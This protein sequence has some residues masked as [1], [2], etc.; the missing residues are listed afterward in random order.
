M[1]LALFIRCAAALLVAAPFTTNLMAGEAFFPGTSLTTGRNSHSATLLTD[2]R[3]LVAGGRTSSGGSGITSVEIL[4]VSGGSFSA[5]VPLPTPRSGHKSLTLPDSR[6]LLWGGTQ[7]GAEIYDPSSD[8]WTTINPPGDAT[9]LRSVTSF[10]NGTLLFLGSAPGN[11]TWIHDPTQN[12]WTT[13]SSPGVVKQPSSAIRLQNGRVLLVGGYDST[14]NVPQT[15]CELFDPGTGTW[16]TTGSLNFGRNAPEL[17]MLADGSIMAI[18]GSNN[19]ADPPEIFD[20]SQASWTPTGPMFEDRSVFAIAPTGDGSVLVSGGFRTEPGAVPKNL[21]FAS[22]ER[23]D[24]ATRTWKPVDSMGTGRCLHQATRLNDGRILIT[25]GWGY[26]NPAIY[27]NFNHA[28]KT[29]EFLQTSAGHWTTLPPLKQRRHSHS[30]IG[31][32]DGRILAYG[33]I[34]DTPPGSTHAIG[35]TNSADIFNPATSMWQFAASMNAAPY[36]GNAVLL[37]DQ[38]ILAVGNYHSETY[39]AATN[40]WQHLGTG[41]GGRRATLLADGKV[42]VSGFSDGTSRLFN[43]VGTAWANTGGTSGPQYDHLTVRL[44]NGT[45]L[46]IGGLSFSGTNSKRCLIYQNGTWQETGALLEERTRAGALM[47]ADGTVLVC[48]GIGVDG[49]PLKTSELYDPGTGTWSSAGRMSRSID[50]PSLFLV[51]GEGVLAIGSVNHDVSWAAELYDPDTDTWTPASPPEHHRSYAKSAQLGDGR[52]LLTG[53]ILKSTP[54]DLSQIRTASPNPLAFET[55]TGM[56]LA[57]GGVLPFGLVQTGTSSEIPIRVRN[58]GNT[59]LSDLTVEFTGPNADAFSL[60]A[61]PPAGIPAGAFATLQIR[62]LSQTAGWKQA[63][64]T[65]RSESGASLP[66]HLNLNGRTFTPGAPEIR[67][68]G[69][70]GQDLT[71]G[72]TV[73]LGSHSI[74]SP[75]DFVFTI[76]NDGPSELFGLGVTMLPTG[77]S[78]EPLSLQSQPAT[79]ELAAGESVT[80][81]VRLEYPMFGQHARILR[82]ISN[83]PDESIFDI[84][85]EASTYRPSP[86]LQIEQPAGIPL[87]ESVSTV[88]FGNTEVGTTTEK[89]FRLV[90]IGTSELRID[91]TYILGDNPTDFTFIGSPSTAEIAPGDHLDFQLMFTP[92]SE[93]QREAYLAVDSNDPEESWFKVFLHGSGFIPFPEISVEQDSGGEIGSGAAPCSF[94][95]ITAG[96][97]ARMEFIVRNTG[98]AP[99]ILGRPALTKDGNAPLTLTETWEELTLDPGESAVTAVEYNPAAVGNH[100]ASLSIPSNDADENPFIIHLSGKSL[101]KQPE[102]SVEQ[103]VGNPLEDGGSRRSFGTADIGGGGTMRTFHIFNRGSAILR[104]TEIQCE[105]PHAKDFN[106]QMPKLANLA[107]GTSTTFKARFRPNKS[108]DRKAIVHVLTNDADET[109]FDLPVIGTGAR[110]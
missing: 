89:T 63:V 93:G 6:V 75:H 16:S 38:R 52:I 49:S 104:I 65:I 77:T 21:I 53:G 46:S 103:P 108:G 82:V 3:V 1:K 101:R 70:A 97:S 94:G 71:A 87:F 17:A 15:A 20:A 11:T 44:Q 110:K 43:P 42:L 90:N 39:N 109:S 72:T 85:L 22:T 7:P 68:S 57:A 28:I 19:L 25:G 48:G 102:I 100:S 59:A 31:L 45:V 8:Q 73:N 23:F 26:F 50:T 2:G 24:L 55:S 64:L 29:S 33:G 92:T 78:R 86:I 67:I 106:I 10:A 37:P 4:D 32:S 36:G 30:V 66:V 99:L 96:T 14:S 60:A 61:N 27:G 88:E 95:S 98:I 41:T 56:N 81:T 35:I 34:G 84:P 54:L 80:F 69:P 51:P 83:D 79:T 107:P 105:G 12:S 40:S 74:E 18:G 9:V 76:H 13:T 62:L 5:A 91:S 47:L 58:R